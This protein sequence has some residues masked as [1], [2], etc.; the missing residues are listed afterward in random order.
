MAK[1]DFKCLNCGKEHSIDFDDSSQEE[2]NEHLDNNCT[3]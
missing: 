3:F 1:F 2:I